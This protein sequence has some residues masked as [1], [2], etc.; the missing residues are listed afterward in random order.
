MQ[1]TVMSELARCHLR[2]DSVTTIVSILDLDADRV[3]GPGDLERKPA[4]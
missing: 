2:V 1:H 4:K 3:H